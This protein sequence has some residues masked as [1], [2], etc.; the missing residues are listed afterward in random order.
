MRIF[1]YMNIT[2][3]TPRH[4]LQGG[5]TICRMQPSRSVRA[6]NRY[7]GNLIQFVLIRSCDEWSHMR[8]LYIFTYSYIYICARVRKKVRPPIQHIAI[9]EYIHTHSHIHIYKS[10]SPAAWQPNCDLLSHWSLVVILKANRQAPEFSCGFPEK[11]LD[12]NGNSET[13]QELTK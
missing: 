6:H 2:I 8:R 10:Y 12:S 7:Y 9:Y 5:V 1:I 4:P 13:Q 3:N 11:M